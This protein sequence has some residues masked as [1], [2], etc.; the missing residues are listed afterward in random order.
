MACRTP[1]KR[2]Q[3][4]PLTGDMPRR[5]DQH[6]ASKVLRSERLAEAHLAAR[7]HELAVTAVMDRARHLRRCRHVRGDHLQNKEVVFLQLGGISNL[8]FEAGETLLDQRRFDMDSLHRGQL[9][10]VELIDGRTTAI[11]DADDLL[12]EV[13]VGMLMTHSL[14]ALIMPKL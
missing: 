5:P 11:A 12:R 6:A 9:E 7:H 2:D 3:R 14:L 10:P 8:A 4:T 13:K 1:L